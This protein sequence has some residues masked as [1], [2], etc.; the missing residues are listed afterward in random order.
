MFSLFPFNDV[1]ISQI[2]GNIDNSDT[3]I[4]IACVERF[5]NNF[6]SGTFSFQKITRSQA[7][8]QEL[9][10]KAQPP[11]QKQILNPDFQTPFHKYNKQLF[12][13]NLKVRLL[14]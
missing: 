13:W 12:C 3:P 14:S 7:K 11:L 9:L 1:E 5:S 10:S 8:E 2:K 4:K 6:K